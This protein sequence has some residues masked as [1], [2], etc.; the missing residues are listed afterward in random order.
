[1]KNIVTQMTTFKALI[2]WVANLADLG[3]TASAAELNYSTNVTSDVQTQLD[4]KQPL[5]TDLT[6]LAAISGVEGDIIYR[7]ATVWTR[8]PKGA[9]LSVLR[10]N[11]GATAPEW[12]P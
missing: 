10:M 9:A 5:D 2:G 3:V 11:A 7:N 6:A 1:M 8:L 12:F 4:A